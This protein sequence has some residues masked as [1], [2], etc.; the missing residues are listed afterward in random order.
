M[1][2]ECK[3]RLLKI[4][5]MLTSDNDAEVVAT[6]RAIKRV[7]GSYSLTIHDLAAS[8]TV[9]NTTTTYKTQTNKP[10]T[11]KPNPKEW[12]YDVNAPSYKDILET[13]NRFRNLASVR[14]DDLAFMESLYHETK[15]LGVFTSLSLMET[16]KFN[17]IK[18]R[19]NL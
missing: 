5:P 3:S 12:S 13:Y 17:D 7:L 15:K 18:R 1:N 8:I 2:N 16:E 19:Y 11:S 14:F 10:S 9:T 4:I 6:V